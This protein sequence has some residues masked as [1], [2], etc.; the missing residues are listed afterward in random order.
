MNPR[1]IWGVFYLT[2]NAVAL[3]YSQSTGELLGDGAGFP[4]VDSDRL[5]LAFFLVAASIVALYVVFDLL[6]RVRIAVH[7]ARLDGH[8]PDLAFGALI[9]LFVVYVQLTGLFVAGSAER[10]GTL[11]SAFFVL[12]NIDLLFL[13]YYA[14]CRHHAG[15]SFVAG[16]WLLSVIQRGWFGYIFLFVALE[17]VRIIRRGRVKP[18]WVLLLLLLVPTFPFLDAVKV[19]IRLNP[20]MEVGELLAIVPRLVADMEIDLVEVLP[21]LVEKI[22]GRLQVLTHAY[23]VIEDQDF[24]LA[25]VE[26]RGVMAFWREGLFGVLYDR[27]FAIERLP[28]SSQLLATFIVPDTQSAWNVNPSLVGWFFIY[29]DA[30][31]FALVYVLLLCVASF[32]LMKKI[33]NTRHARDALWFYW[34]VLLV[35]G[36]ISQFASFVGAMLLLLVVAASARSLSRLLALGAVTHAQHS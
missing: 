32:V 30:L 7:Q 3:L 12:F 13:I 19:F 23:L 9:L 20:G 4:I 27:M 1:V 8:A 33:S 10:G 16:V 6:C 35:P 36:W 17:S 5:Y 26:G 15:F 14:A 22:V 21:V 18:L 24:F 25:E 11:F 34:L 29:G 2:V 28:E 31:P